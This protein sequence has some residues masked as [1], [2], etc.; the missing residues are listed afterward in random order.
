S[1]DDVVALIQR[2]NREG[3]AAGRHSSGRLLID[4]L[5]VTGEWMHT[6]LADLDMEAR[7]LFPVAW[8]GEAESTNL[9]DTA[10]EYT[11]RWHHE[12]QIRTA[13]GDRGQGVALLSEQFAVPLIETAV[14]V[15]PHAYRNAE[16]SDDSTVVIGIEASD[17]ERAYTLRRE[18]NEWRL[19]AG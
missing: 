9:F 1:Y 11:E 12:M 10:R 13:L 19:Y 7:A 16:A 3:V 6:F 15:L 18:A 5:A 17:W 2:L 8:A 4:L 14:R